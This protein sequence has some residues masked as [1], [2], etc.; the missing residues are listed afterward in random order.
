MR[1]LRSNEKACAQREPT[2]K[3]NSNQNARSSL[4][5]K[6]RTA[7]RWWQLG[8]GLALLA[9][10]VFVTILLLLDS[11]VRTTFEGRKWALPAHVYARSLELYVGAPITAQALQEE[12]EQLGY[13]AVEQIS[14]PG[15]YR[16]RASHFELHSR[17]FTFT[18]GVEPARLLSVVADQRIEALAQAD[19][20][21]PLHLLRLEPMR[22]GGIYPAHYEDRELL[23]LEELPALLF[24]A[25]VA[26]ED[27][28]FFN[29]FGLSVS[30][31]LRALK[32][33]LS[34]GRIQ[35]GSTITQQLVKNFYLSSERTLQ[36]KLREAVMALLLEWH[37]SKEQILEAY[38]NEIYLG[39]AGKRAIHG[40]GLAARHYFAKPV[41]ELALEEMA[42]L[43]AVGKGASW[44]NPWNQPQR[45]LK[46]RNLVLSILSR[47]GVVREAAAT[48]AKQQPLAVVPPERSS[49]NRYPAFLEWVKQQLQQ[50][51]RDSDLR[52]EG[53]RIF[54]SFDPLVQGQLERATAQRLQQLEQSYKI[55]A[56]TLQSAATVVRIASGEVVALLGDR[57]PGYAGFNRALDA[58]RQIGSTIKPAI[59]LTALE[60][61]QNYTLAAPVSDRPITLTTDSG[62]LWQPQNFDKKSHGELPLFSALARSYNLAAANLGLELGVDKVL[63]TLRR[64]GLER[65]P[66]AHPALLLGSLA[67]TPMEVAQLYQTIAAEGFFTPLRAIRE[68]YDADQQPLRRY[69]YSAQQR[70][71][72][73]VMHLLHY[74]LQ[75]VMREG[76]GRRAYRWLDRQIASAGKTGTTNDNRDSWFAGFGGDFMGV[77]WVG[78]D[79]NGSMPITG[80]TGALPIWAETMQAIG[81]QPL[82]FGVPPGVDYRWV[83]LPAQQLSAEGCA[84]SY[85]LP[86]ISGT[87]PELMT[88][89]GRAAERQRSDWLAPLRDWW[90]GR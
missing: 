58:R 53:L 75:G 71:S 34:G 11:Q 3:G 90:R 70:F 74:A 15:Q 62:E 38:I 7:S 76:T 10:G 29:H 87:A 49:Y 65:E 26:V 66:K 47:E 88:A 82:A 80:S 84:N 41:S 46:R 2:A 67:L 85:F 18:D 60:D 55:D 72:R 17:S 20:D 57:Q 6:R 36:R 63:D 32:T 27:R 37:Y 61:S 79:D 22:I 8:K 40:Y 64:L 13:R 43:V 50:D 48:H 77:V 19:S 31:T 42:L 9:L 68:V 52:A 5:P 44:Y 89:C 56:N 73:D 30:G 39:Q 86:Y 12:L 69:D 1:L 16:R 24:E 54:T 83:E 81:L 35:G 59:Y 4:R 28:Q 78:R 51:Y 33:N 45:A 21:Q 23:R 14:G 25:V